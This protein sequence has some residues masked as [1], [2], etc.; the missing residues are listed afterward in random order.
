MFFKLK[1]TLLL[2]LNNNFPFLKPSSLHFLLSSLH[3]LNFLHFLSV[4]KI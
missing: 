1:G 3:F 4:A 2:F